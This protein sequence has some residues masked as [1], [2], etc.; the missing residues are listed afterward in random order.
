MTAPCPVCGARRHHAFTAQ[1][2]RRYEVEYLSCTDCGL[3]QTPEPH[4]LDEAYTRAIADADTG[5]L[6]RN[7]SLLPPAVSV[8]S[9]V[10]QRTGT[11]VDVAGGYG[12]FTRLMRDV[13]LDY[14]WHD[15]YAE[16]LFAQGAAVVGDEAVEADAVT[17]FEVL[18]HLP[19][20]VSFI[21]AHLE[22][23]KTRTMLFTTELFEGEPPTKDWWYYAFQTGQHVSFFQERTLRRIARD[24]GLNFVSNGWLHLL[25]DQPVSRLT[26]RALTGRGARIRSAWIRRRMRPLTME[27]H[28][29]AL[30][31]ALDKGPG[32]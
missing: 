9:H 17:A 1:I 10:A 8:L 29:R 14:R 2:L 23:F 3:L 16:N 12:V 15:L 18:E 6:A 5:L 27:D 13:G 7:I 4:W 24:L 28:R 30:T 25:S 22:R 31:E 19:D 21:T 26:F 32:T 20:P 11:F